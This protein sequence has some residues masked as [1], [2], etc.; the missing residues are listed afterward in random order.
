[1]VCALVATVAR[2]PASVAAP[3]PPT[4]AFC[5]FAPPSRPTSCSRFKSVWLA[6]CSF[7]PHTSQ[8][9]WVLD[10]HPKPDGFGCRCELSPVGVGTGAI[11][12]PN[13]FCHG[14]NFWPTGPEPG[15]LSSLYVWRSI[16]SCFFLI[17]MGLQLTSNFNHM[18]LLLLSFYNLVLQRGLNVVIAVS[19]N[20]VIMFWLETY[21]FI[22]IGD[23]ARDGGI[24]KFWLI[25]VVSQTK[26]QLVLVSK[27]R[28]LYYLIL[29]KECENCILNWHL[30]R[31]V[32]GKALK[33]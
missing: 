15:P 8:T 13:L 1:M 24:G 2:D 7:T 29:T 14:L 27:T 17:L 25:V 20:H 10:G 6:S 16:A 33:I 31:S 5:W 30:R 21:R 12:H 4:L 9:R 3:H 28:Y 26:N 11:F 32:C 22:S 18:F 19:N 23:T